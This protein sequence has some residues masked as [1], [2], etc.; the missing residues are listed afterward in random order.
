MTDMNEKV[1]FSKDLLRGAAEI[2]AF[3]LGSRDQRRTIYYLA[4][5]SN[6]PVFKIGSTLCARKSVILKWVEQQEERRRGILRP[7][8]A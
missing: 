8:P 4:T 6:L 5:Y 2:A 7:H 1:E 3:L